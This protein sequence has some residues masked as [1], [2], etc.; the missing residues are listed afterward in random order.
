[1]SHCIAR[2]LSVMEMLRGEQA[3]LTSWLLMLCRDLPDSYPVSLRAG[4]LRALLYALAEQAPRT[5]NQQQ[6]S[7]FREEPNARAQPKGK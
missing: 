4:D 6:G 1:L 5:S 3:R 7:D 2:Y